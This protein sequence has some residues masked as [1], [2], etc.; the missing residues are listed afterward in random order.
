[1]FSIR[2]STSSRRSAV[3]SGGAVSEEVVMPDLPLK[4]IVEI[5]YLAS[6]WARIEQNILVHL[7][8]MRKGDAS[9][10][11]F[12]F[13]R[14]RKAWFAECR[15]NLSPDDF[16]IAERINERLCRRSDARNYVVHGTWVAVSDDEYVATILEKA[17][18]Q[19]GMGRLTLPTSHTA[20]MEQAD[21]VRH[22]RL[23]IWA[24]LDR[25]L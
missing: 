12:G 4:L 23:D 15:E 3:G 10:I 20:L 1:V 6:D 9:D 5:G 21:L 18:D 19:K 7:L 14:L 25:V 13:K 17:K 24:F 11:P 2:L 22:L 16:K 8:E